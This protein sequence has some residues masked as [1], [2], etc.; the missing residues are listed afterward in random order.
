MLEVRTYRAGSKYNLNLVEVQEIR[1]DGAGT[2]AAGE[3]TF[4]Y[5]K[6]NVNHD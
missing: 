2:E 3:Y 5:R 1:W 4:F 6:G